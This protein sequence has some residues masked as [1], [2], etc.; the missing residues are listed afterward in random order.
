MEGKLTIGRMKNS[1]IKNVKFSKFKF[2][3]EREKEL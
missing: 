1:C 2:N 3:K